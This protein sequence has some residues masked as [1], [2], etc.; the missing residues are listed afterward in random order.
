MFTEYIGQTQSVTHYWSKCTHPADGVVPSLSAFQDLL[1]VVSDADVQ[2]VLCLCEDLIGETAGRV[3]PLHQSPVQGEG[4]LLFAC[5]TKT[6][7]S[8]VG[9]FRPCL[10]FIQKRIPRRK[11]AH[12]ITLTVR[13]HTPHTGLQKLI[14]N[15]N[16]K[17]KL[18]A[19]ELAN[20]D[21]H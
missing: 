1:H 15:N 18:L 21:I 17:K 2:S 5:A 19:T 13:I 8:A 20:I 12:I 9:L 11:E 3:R 16:L 10:Q 6:I 14:F 4:V 7:K